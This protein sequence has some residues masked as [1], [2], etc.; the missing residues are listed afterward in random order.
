MSTKC[1]RLDA[2]L[3]F[4]NESIDDSLARLFEFMQIKSVST[5]PAFS[6]EIESAA[7]WLKEELFNLGIESSVHQTSGHPIVYGRSDGRSTSPRVLFYG[8][9]DVQPADPEDEWESSPFEPKLIDVGGAPCI[10]GRGASD[11]KGQ[12]MTF[13]EALRALR[14]VSGDFPCPVTFLIEGEEECGSPSL[15][16][17]LLQ[18]K[19]RLD[20]DLLMAC[21]TDMLDDG[22][23]AITASLRGLAQVEMTITGPSRD[24]HSGGYGGPAWNPLRVLTKILGGLHDD[25]GR[26]LI[27]AFYDGVDSSTSSEIYSQELCGIGDELLRSVGLKSAAG[28]K[29]YS[30]LDQVWRRPTAEINGIWGGYTG[31]GTKTVIPSAAHAKI[32][33]RLVGR[34]DPE[35]VVSAFRQFVIGQLPPDCKAKFEVGTGCPPFE[36]PSDSGALQKVSLALR[37]E[38]GRPTIFIGNGGSIPVVT[39]FRSILKKDALL[40]G[41]AHDDDQVHSP[42]ERY[43]L[44]SFRKGIRSWIRILDAICT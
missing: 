19:S 2:A 8:H 43:R 31:V 30:I 27:P 38:W 40:V 1:S 35:T 15:A 4:A 16:P 17:F 12:L 39:H 5:D 11:D 3:K 29:G 34:Q 37:T 25:S 7:N 26:V 23:P 14:A 36:F 13:I 6:T 22:T 44:E 33:F 24:L 42:D 32:S 21:D 9:Y 10:Y 28:E 41:F 20:C 18:N